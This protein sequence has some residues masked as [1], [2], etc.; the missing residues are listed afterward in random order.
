MQQ[1]IC[2]V[3]FRLLAKK[4]S[5]CQASTREVIHESKVE[6]HSQLTAEELNLSF[7]QSLTEQ[8]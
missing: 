1:H 5:G 2:L 4:Y 3:S 8:H 6:E 7:W